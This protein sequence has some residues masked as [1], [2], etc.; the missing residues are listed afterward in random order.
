M[1][2]PNYFFLL[3]DQNTNWFFCIDKDQTLDL[4]FNNK[5]LYQLS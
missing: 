2:A 5:K 3:L 1:S 4:L